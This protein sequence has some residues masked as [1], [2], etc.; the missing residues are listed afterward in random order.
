MATTTISASHPSATQS[1]V[2]QSFQ[3][4]REELDENNDR[5][6]R[7]IKAS[8]D[9]TNL[10]KKAIF[11]L[12]RV[13]QT[14][15]NA[16]VDDKA[17]AKRAAQ[18]GYEKLREIQDLY[19]K[20]QPELQGDRY[21]RYE[22]QVSPGLQEYIEALSFAHYLDHGSLITYEEVQR[23]LTGADGVQYFPLSVSDYLLGLS[24]LTGELMRF[25]ISSISS[26][27][28]KNK[29]REV[30]AFV[31]GCKSDF[32]RMTPYVRELRKKQSVTTNSLEKIEDAVYTIVVR[33]SEYDLPP[34]MLD[35]IVAHSI[36]NYHDFGNNEPRKHGGRRRGGGASE[37]EEEDPM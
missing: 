2:L 14:E 21:W 8:R 16:S 29:A 24:D 31:R 36:S 1:A 18:Q 17:T 35:D 15:T 5:R 28:G 26:R 9:I 33:S 23:T 34:E 11:L 37:D 7:L 3:A 25:A 22:R 32:E 6:E 30:C 12:H 13:F 20:I 27:G 4:F 10:S 19:A